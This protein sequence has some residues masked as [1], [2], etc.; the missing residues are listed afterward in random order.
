MSCEH[1]DYIE[2]ACM[3]H[4]PIKLTFEDGSE[5]TGQAWDTALNSVRQECIKLKDQQ[6]EQLISLEGVVSL[7]VM[8]DNPH[9]TLVRF[10]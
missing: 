3:H 9:F 6:G 10:T 4:Y 1:Y 8:K 5:V 2:I 7:E